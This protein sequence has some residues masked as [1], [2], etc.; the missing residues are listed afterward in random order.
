MLDRSCI[1]MSYCGHATNFFDQFVSESMSSLVNVVSEYVIK[2]VSSLIDMVCGY[3]IA[4]IT[5]SEGTNCENTSSFFGLFAGI[6]FQKG[7]SSDHQR[8]VSVKLS[9]G[10]ELSANSLGHGWITLAESSN[11]W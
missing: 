2:S 7:N 1:P 4:S 5:R 11:A 10:A 9:W 8:H 3:V 6:L